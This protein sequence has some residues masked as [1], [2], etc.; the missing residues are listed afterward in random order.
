MERLSLL[1][2]RRT[3]GLCSPSCFRSCRTRIL[4]A[5]LEGLSKR[6]ARPDEHL[7][8]ALDR[9]VPA[10]TC[11]Q[12]AL[13]RPASPSFSALAGGRPDVDAA[14]HRVALDLL[15]LLLAEVKA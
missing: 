7:D 9:H 15:E 1:R 4:A 8:T 5:A 13:R 14:L 10:C 12:H 6:S 2:T 11:H 3:G